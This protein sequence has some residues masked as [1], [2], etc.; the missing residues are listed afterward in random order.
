MA[1]IKRMTRVARVSRDR[2]MC[3]G[4]A[5]IELRFKEKA[6]KSNPVRAAAAPATATYRASQ[7]SGR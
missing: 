2:P 6:T 5:V 3:L 1:I 7:L 4:L